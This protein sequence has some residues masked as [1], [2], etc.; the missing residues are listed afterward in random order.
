MFGNTITSSAASNTLDG[1]TTTSGPPVNMFGNVATSSAPSNMFGGPTASS[2]SSS[3]IFNFGAQSAAVDSSAAA[4]Q[5]AP[6]TFSTQ[7]SSAGNIFSQSTASQPSSTAN[8]FAM[9]ASGAPTSPAG[10]SNSSQGVPP[11]ENKTAPSTSSGSN[12][13]SSIAPSA[14]SAASSSTPTFKLGGAS[15]SQ[16]NNSAKIGS[17]IKPSAPAAQ[18]SDIASKTPLHSN[19]GIDTSKT[20]SKNVEAAQSIRTLNAWFKSRMSLVP[21]TGDFAHLARVYLT[22]YD[23]LTSTASTSGS[24][25]QSQSKSSGKRK[26]NDELEPNGAIGAG[27]P[28]KPKGHSNKAESG[29]AGASNTANIFNSI[30]NKPAQS[31]LR[32]VESATSPD[33]EAGPSSNNL[34]GASSSS[35]LKFGASGGSSGSTTPAGSPAKHSSF[36][37]SPLKAPS[38]GQVGMAENVNESKRKSAEIS[39]DDQDEESQDDGTQREKRQKASTPVSSADTGSVLNSRQASPDA[40][41]IF[42]HLSQDESNKGGDDAS[43]EDQDSEQEQGSTTPKAAP[44]RTDGLFGR[45]TKDDTSS[46]TEPQTPEAEGLFGRITGTSS[47]NS[48][49]ATANPFGFPAASYE[50]PGGAKTGPVLKTW[51]GDAGSP[52]KFGSSQPAQAGDGKKGNASSSTSSNPFAGI[53]TSSSATPAPIFKFTPTATP[54]PASDSSPFK[55]NPVGATPSG[56]SSV[57]ASGVGSRATTPGLSTGASENETSAAENEDDEETQSVDKDQVA[58]RTALTEE[59]KNTYDVLFDTDSQ[60]VTMM[61]LVDRSEDELKADPKKGPK[62][63]ESQGKGPVRVLKHKENGVISILFKAE[64]MGRVLINTRVQSS[65][66]YKRAKA[67]FATFPLPDEKEKGKILTQFFKFDDDAECTKFVDICEANKSS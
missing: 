37:Q 44:N 27:S 4:E 41:N 47:D 61:R 10:L 53:A 11:K 3:N 57:F 9:A 16:G 62:K 48:K 55:F 51:N 42:G 64:P 56:S 14:S 13:F 66:N 5:S 34:F 50:N 60:P 25:G 32:N 19:N 8:L 21:E 12:P 22:E 28:K 1:S 58:L 46:E 7:Q 29:A 40:R 59:D 26:A 30:V 43:D 65:F 33:A 35:P 38:F 39:S 24:G 36:T 2:A 17:P 23:K 31:P 52:I 63:W 49:S 67:K 15:S 54:P 20:I 6:A 45:I 18:S